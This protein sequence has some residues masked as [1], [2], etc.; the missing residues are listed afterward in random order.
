MFTVS[1]PL[2]RHDVIQT[3]RNDWALT[4][5]VDRDISRHR[6]VWPTA[7]GRQS[8]N[9]LALGQ[10]QAKSI[11]ERQPARKREQP[12]HAGFVG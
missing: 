2:P 7:L 5:Q 10:S 6:D 12:K 3:Q 1:H 4:D 11:A 9:T 8:W